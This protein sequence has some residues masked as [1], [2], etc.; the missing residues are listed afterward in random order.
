LGKIFHPDAKTGLQVIKLD[1]NN[2]GTEG[3]EYLSEGLSINK[4]VT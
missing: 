3:L 1:H 2:F 4:N